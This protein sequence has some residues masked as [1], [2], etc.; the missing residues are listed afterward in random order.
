[1]NN[2]I[3]SAVTNS[4]PASQAVWLDGGKF[5]SN[6]LFKASITSRAFSSL[7]QSATSSVVVFTH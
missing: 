4:I 3:A 1:L 7:R 5:V 6:Q 2:W